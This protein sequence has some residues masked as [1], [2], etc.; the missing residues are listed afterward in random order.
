MHDNR[1][2]MCYRAGMWIPGFGRYKAGKG[3][4]VGDQAPDF[5]ALDQDSREVHLRAELGS[6]PIVLVFYPKAS[7]PTC[8]KQMCNLR[9]GWQELQGKAKV[10]GVSYDKPPALK[11]F[12]EQ[13]RLPFPL[14]SDAKREI[15]RDYGV[16]GALAAAR[17]SFVISPDGKIKAVVDGVK[18]ASH[19]RQ[20][21]AAL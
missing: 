10:F 2:P 19:T 11:R 15:A 9:D 7:T 4:R 12:Q 20:V 5:K 18:A 16:A 17:V 1:A 13:Q 6:L 3:N 14:L 21:L 8:T